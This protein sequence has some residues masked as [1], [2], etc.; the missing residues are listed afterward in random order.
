[1][2][3]KPE[4]IIR[5]EDLGALVQPK[6]ILLENSEQELIAACKA[7]KRVAQKRIYELFAP[8]MVNVCRRYARDLEQ[9]QDFM[10]DGFIKVFLN[11]S[12]FRGESS[13]ETWITR[14]MINNSISAIKK[15]IRK[16]IKVKIEDA[17]LRETETFD[18]ELERKQPISAKQVFE[19]MEEL[20]IGYKTVLSL[21]VLDGYTHKEI[22]EQLGISDGTSK[23]QLAKAKKMLAKL[24]KDRYQ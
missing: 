24:L 21:Y 12:K 7:G 19:V 6:E 18:Y 2:N 17:K 23:S 15:E 1:L 11:M 22:G 13:L 9:A 5:I 10:H 16:G 8:K 4:H 3:S 14:I 20:P